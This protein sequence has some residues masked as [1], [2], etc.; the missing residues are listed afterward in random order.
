MREMAKLFTVMTLL[1][2]PVMLLNTRAFECASKVKASSCFGGATFSVT[3]FIPRISLGDGCPGGVKRILIGLPSA[4]ATHYEFHPSPKAI[5]MVYCVVQLLTAVSVFVFTRDMHRHVSERLNELQLQHAQV[6]QFSV[7]VTNLPPDTDEH[8]L[9]RH[10]HRRYDLSRPQVAYPIYGLDVKGTSILSGILGGAAV[11][12]LQI[13]IIAFLRAG[14]R[15]FT[16][17]NVIWAVLVAFLLAVLI[18]YG[19]TLAAQQQQLG[20]PV[21]VPPLKDEHKDLRDR[22]EKQL[23][24][25]LGAQKK[26]RLEKSGTAV[27]KA[28]RTG[29]RRAITSLICCR[30]RPPI[31]KA[32]TIWMMRSPNPQPVQDVEHLKAVPGLNH[33]G[34]KNHL[35]FKGKWIADVALIRSNGELIR[36]YMNLRALW[37]QV[38][39]SRASVRRW[40]EQYGPAPNMHRCR[41]ALNRLE[42]LVEKMK[43]AQRELSRSVDRKGIVRKTVFPNLP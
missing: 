32:S 25:M 16:G 9:A 18:G 17:A 26:R 34:K 42:L 21:S 1:H 15:A 5:G 40:S 22:R 35:K 11:F 36:Q 27:T 20:R 24:G 41:K 7:L 6:S 2:L 43:D 31:A 38:Q 19:I 10:F 28:V 3:F 13:A 29:S 39:R 30:S 23:L 8:E 14:G 37:A 12:A 4:S 33:Q